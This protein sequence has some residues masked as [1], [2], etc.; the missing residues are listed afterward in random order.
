M[1]S[2]IAVLAFALALTCLATEAYAQDL[3]DSPKPKAESSS[4]SHASIWSDRPANTVFWLG[5][6]LT[7]AS[8]AAPIIGGN[9][10]R[11][12]NGVE[13]CT[14]HYGAYNAWLGLTSAATVFAAPA[15]FYGCRRDNNNARWCWMVPSVVVAANVGW[16][17]H[18]A[19]INHPDLTPD[20]AVHVT[21]RRRF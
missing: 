3:P 16:G 14:E 19:R 20:A 18:E 15:L 6:A 10:C 5:A 21:A 4:R 12:N 17:I 1:I 9:I 13:P 8:A 2:R 11:R 7:G